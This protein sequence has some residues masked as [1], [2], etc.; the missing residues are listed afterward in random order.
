MLT[1]LCT[2]N[3][4][5]HVFYLVQIANKLFV[6]DQ[7]FFLSQDFQS[8]GMML[9]QCGVGKILADGCASVIVNGDVVAQGSQFSMRDVEVVVA[10]VDLDTV[11][12]AFQ[13]FRAH[14]H[15]TLRATLTAKPQFFFVLSC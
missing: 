4:C 2:E 5:H 9:I 1:V 15:H 10:V 6:L 11:R 14:L 7:I 8:V 12:L 3:S 13:L